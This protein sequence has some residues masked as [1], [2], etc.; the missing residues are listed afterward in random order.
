MTC[1][2]CHHHFCWMCLG[3]WSEHNSSTGGYYRCNKFEEG[4]LDEDHEEKI[5]KALQDQ[6]KSDRYHWYFERF[7][8]YEK[9]QKAAY[10][11]QL[12]NK[13][14]V[15]LLSEIKFYSAKDLA[16]LVSGATEVIHCL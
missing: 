9:S 1:L 13:R 15:D 10:K 6:F 7:K 14:A 5:K 12:S 8:E 2:Y 11:Q 16:F 3:P 4:L